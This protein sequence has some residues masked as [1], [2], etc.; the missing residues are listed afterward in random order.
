MRENPPDGP[1]DRAAKTKDSILDGSLD[2][3]SIQT[4][5]GA[6]DQFLQKGELK[7]EASEVARDE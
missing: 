3:G 5:G 7:I 4:V 1:S 2:S 6:G